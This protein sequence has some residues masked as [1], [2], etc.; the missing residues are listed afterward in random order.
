MKKLA[1]FLAFS[2]LGTGIISAQD[3]VTTS[4]VPE[5]NDIMEVQ[6]QFMNNAL[7]TDGDIIIPD[8]RKKKEGQDFMDNIAEQNLDNALATDGDII[9]PDRRKKKEGQDFMDN[10]AVQNLDNALATDGDIIIPDRRKKKE[11]QDFMDNHKLVLT[12]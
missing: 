1:G 6:L 2:L 9:I 10:I 11:G 12:I 5:N 4:L 7:A 3:I 8:R